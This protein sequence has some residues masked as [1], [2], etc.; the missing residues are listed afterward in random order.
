MALLQQVFVL[1][2]SRRLAD[3]SQGGPALGPVM[4][5]RRSPGRPRGDIPGAT[6]LAGW[7]SVSARRRSRSSGS[8]CRMAR[9]PRRRSARRRRRGR[10]RR[11]LA[12][13][14]VRGIDA[15]TA[16]ADVRQR[17]RDAPIGPSDDRCSLASHGGAAPRRSRSHLY[18]RRPDELSGVT[19]PVAVTVVRSRLGGRRRRRCWLCGSRFASGATRLEA[20]SL[21]VT[22]RCWRCRR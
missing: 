17:T 7:P 21:D 19:R 10:R 2:S 18:R 9:R 20:C 1:R 16:R 13:Q 22:T 12:A 15:K 14:P 6:R 4:P 11:K 3:T 5:P 8:A